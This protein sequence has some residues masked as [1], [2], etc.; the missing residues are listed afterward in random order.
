MMTT[1]RAAAIRFENITVSYGP[2]K[3]L[4]NVSVALQP[5]LIHAVVG[6]NGA[7]KT[8]FGRVCAGLVRP[9]TGR[10]LVNGQPVTAGNVSEARA[11]GVE[12]VHQNFALPPSFTVAEVMEFGSKRPNLAFYSRA[13]L[14][15]RWA[16]HLKSLGVAVDLKAR[17][18]D[19]PVELRQGIEIAKALVNDAQILILDEPTAVL[20]PQAIDQL[21]ERVRVL[22]QRGVTVILILHKLREVMRIADT[23][24]VLR[25][26]KIVEGPV[27]VEAT[28][29]EDLA[30]SIIGSDAAGASAHRQTDRSALV[31]LAT[32]GTQR[33]PVPAST[34][35][36]ALELEGLTTRPDA[37]GSRLSAVSVK[38]SAGE[39][40]GVAGV[41]GNGQRLLV[42]MLA[43]LVPVS[44]GSIRMDGRDIAGLSLRQRRQ[45]GLRIIPFERNL[46]GLSLTST[47]WENWS[48]RQLVAGNAW[49]IVN[50]QALRR[51]SDGDLKKW[52][53]RFDNVEQPAGSLSGGNA[54]K[55]ILAREI[56]E[57]ARVIVAAQPTRG[58]DIAATAFVW[59]TLRAA[60]AKGCGI[61]LISSDLDELFD[62]ADR[63]VVMYSHQ[64]V[65]E[66]TP[67]Y[68]IEA[69]GSAMTGAVA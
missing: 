14:N 45:A 61:L 34:A 19:L 30:R 35:R 67:P 25:G 47:L 38:I 13:A 21:F 48:S 41:E 31:G 24:T 32:T 23:I 4:G 66:F 18:G 52:R 69:V 43:G 62:I 33:A 2:V 1:E 46:E 29:T 68:P 54:Q 39:I 17:V 64:F 42:D 49:Q 55:L 58:L 60:R 7:G 10:L 12:L 28:N 36:A 40:L 57:D 6:Q 11:L 44:H 8:T 65:A 56:T 20:T 51:E 5:G 9:D 53:V 27:P 26:G 22:K 3:A 63:V 59:D 50:P 16:S 37:E 15:E